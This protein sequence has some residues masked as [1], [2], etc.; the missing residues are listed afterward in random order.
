[1]TS[2][3]GVASTADTVRELID[4]CLAEVETALVGGA[5]WWTVKARGCSAYPALLRAAEEAPLDAL[6]G[7]LERL[8]ERKLLRRANAPVGV[9]HYLYGAM[10][11]LVITLWAMV[12][13]ADAA[14]L[15]RVVVLARDACEPYGPF[16]E[17][18]AERVRTHL[19]S[20]GGSPELDAAIQHMRGDPADLPYNRHAFAWL[21]ELCGAVP[22]V[23]YAA[24]TMIDALDEPARPAWRALIEHA[25]TA[26]QARPTKAWLKR[27][28]ELLQGVGGEAYAA[29]AAGWLLALDGERA[30]DW[31]LTEQEQLLVRGVAWLASRLEN[32]A[33]ARALGQAGRALYVRLEYATVRAQ[34]AAN[35]CIYALGQMPGEQPPRELLLLRARLKDKAGL[36]QVETALV[37]AAT[38]RG[39][40]V[41]QLEEGAVS[42]CGLD[43]DGIFRRTVG[44]FSAEIPIDCARVGAVRW[45]TADGAPLRSVAVELKRDHPA[46]LKTLPAAQRELAQALA[47]Q[48]DRLER[49]LVE[50]SEV[51]AAGWRRDYLDHPLVRHL[52]RRLLWSVC[53]GEGER[54]VA[55][56]DG[57]PVDE[58]GAPVAWP[59]DEAQVRLWH[60]IAAAPAAVLRWREWLERSRVVQPIKQAH[61]EVYLLTDAELETR[62]YSNRFAAHI[63]KQHQFKALCDDRRWQFSH[64]G[65]WDTPQE[66]FAL[67]PLP[68]LNLRAELWVEPVGEGTFGNEDLAGSGA[69]L[70][71]A[72][73]QLRFTRPDGTAVPLIELPPVRF[74]ETMRDVDLFVG[75]AG[76]GNDPQWIDRGGE[77]TP[78][79]RDYWHGYAFGELSA[80]AETRY[81]V[82][83]RLLPRLAIAD[84]CELDGRFLSVRGELR[85]YRIHLGSGNILMSPNDQ[86]LCI[87]PARGAAQA[88]ADAVYL[89]FEGDRTLAV[90]L[91]KA[92][93]LA[94]DATI[95]DPSIVRQIRHGLER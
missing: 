77:T 35:A 38:R 54:T 21:D 92:L 91:S 8:R 41:G 87:V 71:L 56:H 3:S 25:A 84:R 69:Y 9:Y 48:R 79:L 85:T 73:D 51:S 95:A 75:V 30:P 13:I 49:M 52:A 57:G 58:R 34:A 26:A 76:I 89:P 18:L 81:D 1:M 64:L 28:D 61:R 67:L 62:T 40:T 50:R 22:S 12:E 88:P 6:F 11:D 72:T 15:A 44:A 20:V 94:N 82:L 66:P 10:L 27:G 60:P 4:G 19:Q 86:Y 16:W 39:L 90:I 74:S 24:R 53:E 33:L 7:A 42:D 45:L 2:P 29:C 83:R 80:Y 59:G 47:V 23:M 43:A 65:A 63:L 36:K 78:R 14:T 32:A 5:Q 17:A 68:R 93:L 70:L 37:E 55:W 31:V 46:E